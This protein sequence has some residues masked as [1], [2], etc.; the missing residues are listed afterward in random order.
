MG[1]QVDQGVGVQVDPVAFRW[2]TIYVAASAAPG[3][4]GSLLRPTQTIAAAIAIGLAVSAAGFTVRV[5]PG[6]YLENIVMPDRDGMAIEGT[7]AGNTIL[8]EAAPGHT[9]DWTPALATGPSVHRFRLANI[10]VTNSSAGFDALHVDGNAVPS[11]ATF[12]DGAFD[13]S[14]AILRKTAAGN[15]IFLRC[16]GVCDPINTSV[17][18]PVTIVNVTLWL[19]LN[20]ALD[21]VQDYTYE[22]ALPQPGTGRTAYSY[23]GTFVGNAF[24]ALGA[25]LILRGH[26]LVIVDDES[27]IIGIPGVGG[28]IDAS[29]LTFA[30]VPVTQPILELA[31]KYGSPLGVGAV[32][33]VN[34]VLPAGAGVAFVDV[35]R[36]QFYN[37]MSVTRPVVGAS[38]PVVL[39]RGASFYSPVPG[40]ITCGTGVSMDLRS[41]GLPQ[42]ALAVTGTGTIDRSQHILLGVPTPALA[43]VVAIAPPFPVST[44]QVSAT[45]TGVA[46]AVSVSAKAT[47]SFTLNVVALGG[48][49]DVAISRSL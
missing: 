34:V 33:Q 11:P 2:R 5:D 8:S 14:Q 16:M 35:S 32:G 31:G 4:D 41:C 42:T 21:G 12:M 22:R 13:I 10:T 15:A 30:A 9:I 18:G 3:G 26:P 17:I 40:S 36:G 7:D 25:R 38:A 1:V 45:P 29:A 49:A 47:G 48:S 39:G 44:Y 6:T 23:A 20:C 43:N 27:Q 24:G 19:A 28:C 46:T 37:G